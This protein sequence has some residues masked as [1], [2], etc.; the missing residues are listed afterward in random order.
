MFECTELVKGKTKELDGQINL[1]FSHKMK[2]G[3]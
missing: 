2:A 1:A 3:S